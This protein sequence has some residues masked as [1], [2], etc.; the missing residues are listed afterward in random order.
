MTTSR[1][2]TRWRSARVHAPPAGSTA[3]ASS[4]A[5]R[6]T[7]CSISTISRRSSS[8]SARRR[9]Q[10]ARPRPADHRLGLA[11]A[12]G[13]PAPA[14]A[15]A[16]RRAPGCGRRSRRPD[17]GAASARIAWRCSSDSTRLPSCCASAAARSRSP[18]TSS[19]SPP[20]RAAMPQRRAASVRG[21][22]TCRHRS[23]AAA[24]A[25]ARDGSGRR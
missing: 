13:D 24:P 3:P 8:C 22:P 16:H 25:P 7:A 2:T 14:L 4:A 19:S 9:P 18:R 6:S 10:R 1:C 5:T 12:V 23:R 11:A 17:A 15:P 21:G 20:A